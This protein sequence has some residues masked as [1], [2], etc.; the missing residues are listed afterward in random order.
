M[1][2]TAECRRER[3]HETTK[4]VRKPTPVPTSTAT[5]KS[6]PISGGETTLTIAAIDALRATSAVASFSRLSPSRIVTTRRGSP[7]RPAIAVTAI[8]SVG[9]I[10]AASANAAA[11]VIDGISA[12][13]A[14]PT[15]TTV[16]ATSPTDSSRMLSRRART[17]MTDVR[18]AAANSSGGRMP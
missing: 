5:T 11:S 18:M 2:S 12:K 16:N 1:S 9:A 3:T 8:A 6:T 7:S 14:N 17:S 13:A 15:V 4:P 10:T